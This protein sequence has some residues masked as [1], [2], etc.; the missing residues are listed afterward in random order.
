MALFSVAKFHFPGCWVW[1]CMGVP[2]PSCMGGHVWLAW[3]GRGARWACG[4]CGPVRVRT[5]HRGVS[6]SRRE[7]LTSRTRSLKL[8]QNAADFKVAFF[9]LLS[10]ILKGDKSQTKKTT[11]INNQ[12]PSQTQAN[13]KTQPP[14]NKKKPPK[15]IL[16]LSF[17][18]VFL[19]PIAV[20][21]VVFQG[22]KNQS[23][24]CLHL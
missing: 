23:I 18:I 12:S 11:T 8:P 17:V 2:Y 22:G 24:I 1:G 3:V 20:L 6:V 14:T 5:W 15:T 9:L 7:D 16:K 10:G 13:K 19:P 21:L 4:P